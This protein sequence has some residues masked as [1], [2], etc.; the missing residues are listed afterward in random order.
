MA[1]F[2][3]ILF[4]NF[5]FFCN[6]WNRIFFGKFIKKGTKLLF[7]WL[8][9]LFFFYWLFFLF[10]FYW[11]IF[12]FFIFL[13][14]FFIL[15]FFF[16]FFFFLLFWF[17]FFSW[18]LFLFFIKK[19]SEKR[20]KIHWFFFF[21][22]W[23]LECYW[24]FFNFFIFCLILSCFF[25]FFLFFRCLWFRWLTWFLW[26]FIIFNFIFFFLFWW[27]RLLRFLW[28]WRGN[29]INILF[30]LCFIWSLFLILNQFPLCLLRL[31]LPIICWC[32]WSLTWCLIA[33]SFKLRPFT[34]TSQNTFIILSI[35]FIFLLFQ[36]LFLFIII[37]IPDSLFW[38]LSRM[39]LMPF[40][41]CPNLII[42][43]IIFIWDNVIKITTFYDINL[44][45]FFIL[46]QIIF[47]L[48]L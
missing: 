38:N 3:F 14:I 10:F 7:N 43:K 25:V 11:L 18:R 16:F 4:F 29:F 15:F 2:I 47:H 37:W 28:F 27:F 45:K 41:Y 40:T 26:N 22:F 24:C 6:Y 42:I 19:I 33:T 31:L 12:F 32:S 13:F 39:Y 30:I 1:I 23:C 48:I 21:W 34:W 8:I 46:L 17:I 9:F 20:F 5:L 35:F 44:L 36:A